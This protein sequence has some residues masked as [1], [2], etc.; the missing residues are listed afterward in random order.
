MSC[1][2]AL[3]RKSTWDIDR[4]YTNSLTL[5]RLSCRRRIWTAVLKDMSLVRFHFSILRYTWTFSI[6]VPAAHKPTVSYISDS[7]LISNIYRSDNGRRWSRTT[8][9]KWQQIYSL[10]RYLLRY[11]LPYIFIQA[12]GSNPPTLRYRSCTLICHLLHFLNGQNVIWG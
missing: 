12:E 5:S 8:R 9:A 11:I 6:F 2:F 3:M 1:T 10:P 7:I 4:L